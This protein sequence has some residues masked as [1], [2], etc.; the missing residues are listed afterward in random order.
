MSF[1]S[2]FLSAAAR[3]LKNSAQEPATLIEIQPT[4]FFA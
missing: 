3:T 1:C 2:V 4:V